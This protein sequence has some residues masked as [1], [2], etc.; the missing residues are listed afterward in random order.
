MNN[1][2]ILHVNQDKIGVKKLSKSKF[3]IKYVWVI[4]DLESDQLCKVCIS[5]LAAQ[6]YINNHLGDEG[7]VYILK[8]TVIN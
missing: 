4:F 7:E 1:N 8:I 3:D 5:K 6:R 2:S